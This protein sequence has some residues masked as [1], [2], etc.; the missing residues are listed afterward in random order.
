ML[1][2]PLLAGKEGEEAIR[3]CVGYAQKHIADAKSEL[4]YAKY[5]VALKPQAVEFIDA[6][7]KELEQ[8]WLKLY[9][10]NEEVW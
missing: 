6:T 2:K 9:R 7:L 1:E 3:K 4:Q 5:T 8:L 10:L